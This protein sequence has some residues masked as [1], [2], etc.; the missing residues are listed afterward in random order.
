MLI[1]LNSMG[2][3]WFA[4]RTTNKLFFQARISKIK[5]IIFKILDSSEYILIN[6]FF[7]K[8]N[9]L[10]PKAYSPCLLIEDG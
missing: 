10:N 2:F 6:I 5:N 8:R 1:F 9:N 4:C 3:A 7:R